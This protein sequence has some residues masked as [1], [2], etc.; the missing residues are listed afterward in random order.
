MECI[1]IV[2]EGTTGDHRL[3]RLRFFH[4]IKA[5]GSKTSRLCVADHNDD[6]HGFLTAATLFRYILSC[7]LTTV[8]AM[9]RLKLYSRDVTNRFVMSTTKLWRPVYMHA[10]NEMRLEKYTV[11]KVIRLFYRIPESLTRSLKTYMDY[12]KDRLGL[13]GATLDL[14]VLY[15][16]DGDTLNG[17]T[18]IHVYKTI[19]VALRY[20]QQRK[21]QHPRSFIKTTCT[22]KLETKALQQCIITIY[23]R[24]GDILI[25][26]VENFIKIGIIKNK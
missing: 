4:P 1:G 18:G 13:N 7:S 11:L 5:D 14:C 17:L 19:F 22:N 3:Y 16:S 12:C 20:S 6:E 23:S 9:R 21:K 25:I 24:R 8:A 10:S 15:R 26:Q 2:D